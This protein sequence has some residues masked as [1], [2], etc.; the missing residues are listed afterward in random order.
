[1]EQRDN[2]DMHLVVFATR[3]AVLA[4]VRATCSRG[5]SVCKDWFDRAGKMLHWL[6][7]N[8]LSVGDFTWAKEVMELLM[9]DGTEEDDPLRGKVKLN[10]VKHHHYEGG[11]EYE[12]S[13]TADAAHAARRANTWINNYHMARGLFKVQYAGMS[14]SAIENALKDRAENGYA[15]GMPPGATI[16]LEEAQRRREAGEVA[17]LEVLE[18]EPFFVQPE[19]R[20]GKGGGHFVFTQKEM[21]TEYFGKVFH[22]VGD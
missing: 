3:M 9:P 1:M 8:V 17:F 12:M 19:G 13:V 5:A 18:N 10:R 7:N 2:G 6:E 15:G 4:F 22:E 16:S 21:R 11:Y 20:R 14:Q